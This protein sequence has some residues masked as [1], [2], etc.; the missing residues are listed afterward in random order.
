ME[1]ALIGLLGVLVG[2]FVNEHF[3]KTNRIENYSS[4]VFEKRLKIYE[5]LMAIVDK[6][7][8]LG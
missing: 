7:G 5:E 1:E 6:N 3:R 2:L 4:T 8:I